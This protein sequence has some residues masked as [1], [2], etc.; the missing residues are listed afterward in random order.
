ML[1]VGLA[2]IA[3]HAAA[4]GVVQRTGLTIDA[5]ESRVVIDVGKAGVFAFAGHAH[6]VIAPAV[7]GTVTLDAGDWQRSTVSLEFDAAALRVSPTSEAQADV[8]E[9]QR[10]M[11]GERVLDVSHFP[12]VTFRS[13]RV[14]VTPTGPNSGD[15]EIEGDLTLHGVTRLVTVRAA[16]TLDVSG[17]LTTRGAFAVKQTDFNI[18]PVTAAG[19]SIRVRDEVDVRFVLKARQ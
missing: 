6:E 12:T 17:A 4:A 14:S 9:V 3:V 2:A 16:T 7:R 1:S 11:L 19:G 8:P 18:Q 15:L 13:R 5:R 10:V